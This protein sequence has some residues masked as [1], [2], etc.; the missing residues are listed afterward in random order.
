[1]NGGTASLA[2]GDGAVNQ[3]MVSKK[4]IAG[5]IDIV[6]EGGRRI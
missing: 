3:V 1:M 5:L 6:C 4:P 2:K